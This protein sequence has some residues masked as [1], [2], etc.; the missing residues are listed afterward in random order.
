MGHSSIYCAISKLPI[1]SGEMVMI[2]IVKSGNLEGLNYAFTG[3]PIFGTYNTYSSMENIE[4]TPYVEA[5]EKHFGLS[6]DEIVKTIMWANTWS[7]IETNDNIRLVELSQLSYFPIDREI[8]D[9]II[10]QYQPTEYNLP[11]YNKHSILKFLGFEMYKSGSMSEFKHKDCETIFESNWIGSFKVKNGDG[12]SLSF[13]TKHYEWEDTFTKYFDIPEEKKFII[14]GKPEDMFKIMEGKEFWEYF[15]WILGNVNILPPK[16]LFDENGNE[17][18]RAKYINDLF[19]KLSSEDTSKEEIYETRKKIS[20]LID[21]DIEDNMIKIYRDNVDSYKDEVLSLYKLYNIM[22]YYSTPLSPINTYMVTQDG[23]LV[24]CVKIINL[25]SEVSNA[26]INKY[27][28][29]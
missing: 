19:L 2:P 16:P 22:I 4:R 14:D 1:T 15:N 29:E 23:E 7:R 9:K 10:I 6:I 3:F 28:N 12:K 21:T 25:I 24:E 11:T 17:V 20:S 13:N 8:W 18:N 5:L 26:R 27:C